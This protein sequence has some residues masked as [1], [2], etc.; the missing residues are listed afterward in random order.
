MK[1]KVM[2][3]ILLL[4]IASWAVKI[5]GDHVDGVRVDSNN[6]RQFRFSTVESGRYFKV[7]ENTHGSARYDKLFEMVMYAYKTGEAVNFWNND[8]TGVMFFSL[9]VDRQ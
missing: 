7:D 4:V 6:L 8:E 9:G 3:F 5:T 1:H 2:F